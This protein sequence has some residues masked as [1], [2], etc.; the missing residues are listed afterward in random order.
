[1][2]NPLFVMCYTAGKVHLPFSVHPTPELKTHW[3][4]HSQGN[5]TENILKLSVESVLIHYILCFAM[6]SIIMQ[7]EN[8]SKKISEHITM[9]CHSAHLHWNWPFS[10]ETN[11]YL[12][13]LHSRYHLSWDWFL[14]PSPWWVYIMNSDQNQQIQCQLQYGHGYINECILQTFLTW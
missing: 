8:A 7:I 5:K 13:I 9:S 14:N 11:G 12:H 1:M 3:L 6:Y 10:L 4:D 2:R